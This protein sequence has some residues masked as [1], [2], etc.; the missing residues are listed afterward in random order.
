V[1]ETLF[2]TE[3][4]RDRRDLSNRSE[5]R[6]GEPLVDVVQKRISVKRSSD[7]RPPVYRIV[8]EDFEPI[9]VKEH[10]PG[11][12]LGL[13]LGTEAADP[14]K[15][16]IYGPTGEFEAHV[17]INTAQAAALWVLVAEYRLLSR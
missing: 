12:V 8:V 15:T 3:K 5:D 4:L 7:T 13:L 14:L 16:L 11:H 17:W 2:T 6:G 9:L 10:L 1:P